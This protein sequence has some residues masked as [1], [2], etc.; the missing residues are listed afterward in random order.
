[1]GVNRVDLASGET[2]INLQGDTIEPKYLDK[3]ITAHDASGKPIVG[4]RESSLID[5]GQCGDDV[6]WELYKN[7]LLVISGSGEFYD[8]I[9]S[10]GDSPFRNREDVIDI[11][12]K[13]G[14]ISIGAEVFHSCTNLKSVVIQEGLKDIDGYAFG[15]C[16]SLESITF[17]NSLTNILFGAFFGCTNLTTVLYNGSKEDWDKIY[18]SDGNSALNHAILYC[19]YDPNADTVD[20]WHVNVRSDGSNPPEGITNTISFV[21]TEG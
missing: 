12:I 5:S 9:G 20:G 18:I 14:V 4:T 2:L 1:M 11:V 16:S 8:Y 19:E 17:P 6:Y 7:G 10:S 3:G 15:Y 13:K 21:Y